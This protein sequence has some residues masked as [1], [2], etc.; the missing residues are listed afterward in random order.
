MCGNELQV[1]GGQTF[2]ICWGIGK[3]VLDSTGFGVKISAAAGGGNCAAWASL[4]TTHCSI[5]ARSTWY[6]VA[7]ALR[8]VVDTR[9]LAHR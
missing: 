8:E 4:R 2:A 3:Q 6:L 1:H 7:R 5:S 9:P